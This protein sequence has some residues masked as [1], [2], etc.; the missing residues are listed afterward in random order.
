[1]IEVYGRLAE[2]ARQLPSNRFV[3]CHKSYLVNLAYVAELGAHELTLDDATVLPVSRRAAPTARLRR[4]G[5]TN[6]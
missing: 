6:R 3:R 5:V 2:V 1:M 4:C